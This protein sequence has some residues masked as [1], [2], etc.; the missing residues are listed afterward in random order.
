MCFL[1]ARLL[2]AWLC[3]AAALLL[4]KPNWITA[5]ASCWFPRET[6]R[7]VIKLLLFSAAVVHAAAERSEAA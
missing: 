2:L 1:R 7:P 3:D 5:A 6:S 4:R